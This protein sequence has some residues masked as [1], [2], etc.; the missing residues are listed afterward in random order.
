[1]NCRVRSWNYLMHWN[2]Y[3]AIFLFEKNS[4]WQKTEGAIRKL[5]AWLK[6]LPEKYAV[7]QSKRGDATTGRKPEWRNKMWS[8]LQNTSLS[9]PQVPKLHK[10]H[11]SALLAICKPPLVARWRS[12]WP[13]SPAILGRAGFKRR[14]GCPDPRLLVSK[15]SLVARGT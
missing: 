2:Q 8:G 15:C 7:K 11:P 10:M 5:G 3:Q 13:R 1:M 12:D 14:P 4:I 9:L 6:C